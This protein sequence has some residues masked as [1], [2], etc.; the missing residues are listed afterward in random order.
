MEELAT[1]KWQNEGEREAVVES[2]M[3]GLS[4]PYSIAEKMVVRSLEK[5]ADKKV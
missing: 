5:L 3:A 1:L 2:M 4:D